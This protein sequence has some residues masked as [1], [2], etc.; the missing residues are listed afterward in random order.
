M[1][2]RL[3]HAL[4][5]PTVQFIPHLGYVDL[6]WCRQDEHLATKHAARIGELAQKHESPYLRVFALTSSGID[7]FVSRDY[8]GAIHDFKAC[9]ELA[10]SVRAALEYEPE[11]L[12]SLAEC[13]YALGNFDAA[14]AYARDA[15]DVATQRSA[16]LPH[17]RS[18]IIYAAAM[19][20]KG[21]GAR[22]QDV[23]DSLLKAES[24][25]AM[26]GAKIYE[27]LLQRERARMS[28]LVS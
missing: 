17:C 11:T 27:P 19:L 8:V 13:N 22:L 16:R 5:D 12:A 9:L 6:A 15:I 10:H 7:K 24:L 2:L 1:M 28:A 4:I 26:S 23:E 14:I 25:I 18:L 20:A 3:E 21:N